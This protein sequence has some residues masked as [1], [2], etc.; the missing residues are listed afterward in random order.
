M[1]DYQK[2]QFNSINNI[3]DYV[4]KKL[5]LGHSI[6][7]ILI[8]EE[9]KEIDELISYANDRERKSYYTCY[10]EE[11]QSIRNYV[12]EEYMIPDYAFK[13]PERGINHDGSFQDCDIGIEIDSQN[14]IEFDDFEHEIRGMKK[15]YNGDSFKFSIKD[16]N[17][18]HCEFFISN[19]QCDIENFGGPT[20]L[21][22]VTCW[23]QEKEYYIEN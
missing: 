1:R 8:N 23:M 10:M 7:Q 9:K 4:T 20:E 16:D 5:K 22:F 13:D 17:S 3:A 18:Y 12:I 21:E 15:Y 6:I 11:H 19:G 2:I 14:V